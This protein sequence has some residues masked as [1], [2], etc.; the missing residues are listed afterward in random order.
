MSRIEGQGTVTDRSGFVPHLH[1]EHGIRSPL[2][3]RLALWARRTPASRISQERPA[4]DVAADGPEVESGFGDADPPRERA[5]AVGGYSIAAGGR[6]GVGRVQVL[7]YAGCFQGLEQ[8]ETQI[9][10]KSVL[11][12]VQAGDQHHAVDAEDFRD[13]LA[14]SPAEG[15]FRLVIVLD[16]APTSWSRSSATRSPSPPR[17]V[18]RSGKA[19]RPARF[20]TP[21]QTPS[22]MLTTM[23]SEVSAQAN[24]TRVRMSRRPRLELTVWLSLRSTRFPTLLVGVHRKRPPFVTCADTHRATL[25]NGPG[26]G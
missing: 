18:P 6:G 13:G 15:S 8:L 21:C 1:F 4:A 20:P 5:L 7:S 16:S 3:A 11:A 2:R 23:P 26:R 22:R 17:W 10:G 25:V 19:T 12:A 24:L 14:R 9:L